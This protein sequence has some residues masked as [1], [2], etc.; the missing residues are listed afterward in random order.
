L[1][2]KKTVPITITLRLTPGKIKGKRERAANLA[3]AN[4]PLCLP[5]LN[6]TP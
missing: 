6:P 1:I 5:G 4:N 2:I 3:G